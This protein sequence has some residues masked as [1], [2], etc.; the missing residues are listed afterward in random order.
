VWST[1]GKA[2]TLLNIDELR[3]GS[4]TVRNLGRDV[5]GA[6][7]VTMPDAWAMVRDELAGSV[8]NVC[9]VESVDRVSL[10]AALARHGGSDL[11]VGIGGGM[12]LDA[13][14]YFSWRTAAPLVTIPTVISTNAFATEAVGVREAGKVRY[15]GSV[16]SARCIVDFDLIAASPRPLSLGGICDVL[17]C[18]TG[19]WDWDHACKSG[20]TD[21]PWDDT[22]ARKARLLVE[23]V[24]EYAGDIRDVSLAGI[25]LVVDLCAATA[26]I[27]QPM[28]HF[29]AEE[30]SE[31]FLMYC[32]ESFTGRHYF[33]GP[34]V[35][36]GIDLM[37]RLQDNQNQWICS[38]IDACGLPRAPLASSVS[39]AELVRALQELPQFV[40]DEQLWYSVANELTMTEADVNAVARTLE[41]AD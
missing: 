38:V 22:A 1:T 30:G 11:V 7:V 24:A 2:A 33:H 20:V 12:A 28:G 17:S 31:H 37:S 9:F 3:M 14:K 19:L 13:A 8:R 18:H 6:L 5:A 21:H 26:E 40:V 27:C 25:K 34:V 29:R 10:D 16:R 41:F 35:A 36:L 32:L 23:Q 4:G 15:V 39:R